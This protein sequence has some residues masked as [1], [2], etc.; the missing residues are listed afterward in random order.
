MVFEP[1][2]VVPYFARTIRIY[3]IFKA[4]D[5][6][7]REKRKPDTWFRWIKEPLMFKISLISLGV[8]LVCGIGVYI[9]VHS[10]V[11]V[12]Q[13]MPSYTIYMCFTEGMCNQGA[14]TDLIERHVNV[15][16]VWLLAINFVGSIFFVTCIYKLRNIKNEFNIRFE[17][18]LTFL[19]WFAAT[20]LALGLYVHQENGP[21]FDWV[22]LILVARSVAAVLLT[23]GRPLYLSMN[24]R[25]NHFLLL[26]PNQESI[27]NLD[28][29][30]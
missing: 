2:A 14:S 15:T 13:Y 30:L 8:L 29:V 24:A 27:E 12:I 20:Q 19:V 7:F 1:M 4:Q 5:F 11:D 16:L 18:L 6:Y 17:L 28:I 22:Y 9:G 21:N 23:A 3:T 26:P 10:N 25:N